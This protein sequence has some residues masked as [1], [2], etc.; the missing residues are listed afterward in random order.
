[1]IHYAELKMLIITIY[2]CFESTSESAEL[3]HERVKISRSEDE[4]GSE[5]REQEKEEGQP[6]QHPNEIDCKSLMYFAISVFSN[7]LRCYIALHG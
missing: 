4:G 1:M 3:I 5:L 7:Y 2:C 6:L